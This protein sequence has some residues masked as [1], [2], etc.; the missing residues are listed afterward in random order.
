M[1]NVPI[2]LGELVDKVSILKIKLLKMNNEKLLNVQKEYSLL[3]KI[4]I[5]NGITEENE[6]FYNLYE[7]NLKFWNYHDWQREKWKNNDD[8][9]IDIELYK[10]N[11]NEHILNDKRAEIKK[12]INVMFKSS[13]IEEKQFI[14]YSI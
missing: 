10:K 7:L 6:M 11:K 9:L 5:E 2:S 12:N 3:L 4:M 14:S 8:N 13:I 1:I